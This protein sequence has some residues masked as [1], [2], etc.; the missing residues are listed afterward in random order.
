MVKGLVEMEVWLIMF[1]ASA[2]VVVLFLGIAGSV[3]IVVLFGSG[4]ASII[5]STEKAVVLQ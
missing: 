3:E 2:E 1:V 5:I 4:D